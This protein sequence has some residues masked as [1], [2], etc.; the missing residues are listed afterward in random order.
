MDAQIFLDNFGT[1][2]DAPGGVDRLRE[3]ILD[4]AV[5]GQLVPQDLADGDA[6]HLLDQAATAKKQLIENGEVLK[7]RPLPNDDS[8]VGDAA[9]TIP[10]NWKWVRLDDVAVYI[11]R[12]KGPTYVEN[13]G[14]PVVS[15]KCIQ[16]SGFDL[17]RA[18][19]VDEATLASYGS[20]R[21]LRKGDLLW[22]STGTGTV[23]RINVFPGSDDYDQVVADS[24]V[25]VVRT[26][27]CSPRYLHCWLSSPEVQS[28]IEDRTTGTTKQHELNTSTVRL[29][30]VPLPPRAEQ[31]RIVA[32]VDELMQLCDDLETR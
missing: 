30:P 18:R 22:N 2:A 17:A 20:E 16:N 28:T 12:G 5:R 27:V 15:Q 31:E 29:Q 25:T 7:S 21:F 8:G 1:I 11:Q 23:G 3:L 6:K 14:V 10:P 26:V 9:F 19:F 32:K 24:H 4:L 13:S